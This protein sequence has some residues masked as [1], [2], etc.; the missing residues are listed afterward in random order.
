MK[1]TAHCRSCAASLR[2]DNDASQRD[3]YCKFCVDAKGKVKS[4]E[5]VCEGVKAWARLAWDGCIGGDP[6]ELDRWA[7]D[8]LNAMPHW[9][10]GYEA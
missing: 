3:H 9:R 6:G 4:R 1:P 10:Y 7:D 8:Y 2:H 5:E